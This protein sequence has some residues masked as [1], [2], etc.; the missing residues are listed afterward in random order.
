[1]IRAAHDSDRSKS[2]IH[3]AVTPPKLRRTASIQLKSF[4]QVRT[5][6]TATIRTWQALDAD[7]DDEDDSL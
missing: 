1:M 3:Q 6:K 7:F 2:L 4:S 5:R